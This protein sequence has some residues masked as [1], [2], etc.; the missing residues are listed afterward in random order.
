MHSYLYI[1]LYTNLDLPKQAQSQ[2]DA[3][4]EGRE[5]R[6]TRTERFFP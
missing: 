5:P 2:D 1:I 4:P 3:G 6:T